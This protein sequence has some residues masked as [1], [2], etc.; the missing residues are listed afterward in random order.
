MG[1][2]V[3]SSWLS[4]T[5]CLMHSTIY[6]EIYCCRIRRGR[7]ITTGG[8]PHSQHSTRRQHCI[9]TLGVFT[10]VTPITKR[11]FILSLI[12]CALLFGPNGDALLALVYIAFCCCFII[13]GRFRKVQDSAIA[14]DHRSVTTVP[15]NIR[16]ITLN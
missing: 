6:N 13:T 15:N 8:Q 9:S 10:S 16:V 3:L 7:S 14:I 4:H 1:S 2:T 5:I 12:D 11:P